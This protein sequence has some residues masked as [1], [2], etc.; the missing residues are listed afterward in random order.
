MPKGFTV[1]PGVPFMSHHGIFFLPSLNARGFL[2]AVIMTAE[3]TRS[4]LDLW[5]F[6]EDC[7]KYCPGF[8]AR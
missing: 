3:N 5:V 7:L 1:D 6:A 4:S 8:L 2:L